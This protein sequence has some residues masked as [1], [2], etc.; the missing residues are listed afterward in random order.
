MSASVDE[1]REQSFRLLEEWLKSRK[2]RGMV[3]RNTIGVGI[4]VLDHLRR[5][6]PIQ[7]S[8]IITSGGEIKGSRH[9]L[10]QVLAKYGIPTTFLKEITTRQAPQDGRRLLDLLQWGADLGRLPPSDRDQLLCEMVEPLVELATKWLNRQRLK[11]NI[12]RTQSPIVWINLILD[13]AKGRSGGVVEQH[14]VGAKLAQ[15]YPDASIPNHPAHAADVQ[16]ERTGDFE[17]H[18]TTYHVTGAP[19]SGVIEKCIANLKA[20]LHPVLLVPQS[21][22]DKAHALAE[23]AAVESRITIMSIEDFIALNIIEMSTGYQQD[24]FSVL[25]TIVA[26]YNQRLEKAETDLSLQIEMPSQV[27]MPPAHG[28]FKQAPKVEKEAGIQGKLDLGI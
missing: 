17:I 8:E 3:S 6:C 2:R 14:L 16:T 24:F 7:P 18:R 22:K 27:Q 13:E 4:V 12:D 10:R 11:I 9:G 19:T 23:I 28:T 15:R 25:Q 26:T 21:K 20:D 1:V 5:Q